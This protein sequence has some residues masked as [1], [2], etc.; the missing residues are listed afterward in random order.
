MW[1]NALLKIAE[2]EQRLGQNDEDDSCIVCHIKSYSV[3]PVFWN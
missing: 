2:V 3:Q 1:I